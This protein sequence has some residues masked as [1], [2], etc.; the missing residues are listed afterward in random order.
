MKVSLAEGS[1]FCFGVQRA[2]EMAYKYAYAEKGKKLYSFHEIIHNPQEASRM[3]KAGAKHV[4]KI[5]SVTKGSSVIISTHGITQAEEELLKKKCGSVLDTTCPYVKKI[6]HIVRKLA[7]ENYQVIIVGDPEHLEVKGILG[8]ARE[9]GVVVSCAEE[10]QKLRIKEK[11]GIVSQTTQNTQTYSEIICAIREKAFLNK[12]AEVRVFNTI[13]GAT[14]NRQKATMDLAKRSDIMV[15]VG[16]KNS[17]N[18]RRL[19]EISAGI[20]SDVY[21]V[22]R[23]KEIQNVWFEG[24]RNAGVSAGASTPGSVIEEVVAKIMK[25]GENK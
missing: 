16:G 22:E 13:C 17:A 1:G 25:I 10:I 24:K 2:V 9:N 4:E 3:E 6:H 7:D 21:H 20:L 14:K 5:S 11:T 18:T 12:Y 19:F 8:H 15:I 23:S